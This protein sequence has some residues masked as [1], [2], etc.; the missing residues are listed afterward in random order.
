MT[1]KDEPQIDLDAFF[2]QAIE[3]APDL[4][5]PLMANILADAGEVSA[6]RQAKPIP[7]AQLPRSLF[8]R[9]IEPLG[10]LR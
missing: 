2:K 4:S 7:V 10:G 1:K 8:A 9:L 3:P 6:E 5:S